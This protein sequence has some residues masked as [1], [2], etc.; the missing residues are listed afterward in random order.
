MALQR[1]KAIIDI[2]T[3]YETEKKEQAIELLRQDARANSLELQLRNQQL[4][5]QQ[6]EADKRSQQLELVSQ[7]NEI[8]KLDASQKALQLENEVQKNEKSVT[9]LN[10]LAG[11]AAFQKLLASKQSQQKKSI[12]NVF[13]YSAVE[14]IQD[15][16]SY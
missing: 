7:Q 14:I 3:R 13:A 1:Q 9:Q 6:L 5:E 10:L 12:E 4:K 8:N 2:S 11:E 15:G 16:R